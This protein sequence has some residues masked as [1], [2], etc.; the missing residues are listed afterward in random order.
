MTSDSV[1]DFAFVE[2]LLDAGAEERHHDE[3]EHLI[4]PL[5]GLLFILNRFPGSFAFSSL[6]YNSNA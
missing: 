6:T 3:V 2:E 5:N 1:L 4:V